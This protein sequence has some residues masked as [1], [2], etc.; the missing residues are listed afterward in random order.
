MLNFNNTN[1]FIPLFFTANLCI[2][3]F[4][5]IPLSE[6]QIIPDQ[7]LPNPTLVNQN[8]NTSVITGGTQA[9][10]N[11]FHSF[12]E[13]SI[14]SGNIASFRHN[15]DIANILSRVTGK[16]PS[17]IDGVIEVL[18]N[19][20]AA[21]S[22]NLFLINPSGIVFGQNASLN[23][24]GSFIT[25]TA[26]SFI[27][28]NGTEF[29]AVNP[30]DNQ[31]LLTINVPVGLQF[32]SNP[33][34]IIHQSQSNDVGLAV[35]P[36]KTLAFVGGNVEL[37][38]GS[39]IAP[40]GRIELGSV[41]SPGK[42]S[43]KSTESGFSLGYEGIEEF[44]DIQLSQV[45]FI[46]VSGDVGGDVT[47]NSQNLKI[48][49]GSQIASVISNQGKGS[50][51]NINTR[52]NLELA[53]GG[54]FFL[55]MNDN[56]SGKGTNLLISTNKLLI[57]NG[58]F[59]FS[60]NL[61]SGVGSDIQVKA[62]FIEF[63]G[64]NT[65]ILTNIIGTG[66]GGDIKVDTQ[67]LSLQNGSQIASITTASGKGGNIDIVVKESLTATG[68]SDSGSGIF[69]Q[70]TGT[71]TAG[72]IKI[73][74]NQLNLSNGAQINSRTFADGDA[75]EIIV[76][77]ENIDISGIALDENGEVITLFDNL[78]LNSGIFA[79]TEP[80]SSGNAAPLT[81]TTNNLNISD[82]GLVETST[83]S[84]GDGS[85]LTINAK[86]ILLSGVSK[87]EIFPASILSFSGGFLDKN[88]FSVPD[89]TGKGGSVNITT[90]NLT[91]DNQAQIAVSS[92]N[93]TDAAKGAGNIDINAEKISL[94]N[95]GKLNAQSNSGDGG[96]IKLN[97]KDLLVLRNNS[98][99]STTAGRAE[100]GG[101]G[102][103]IDINVKDGFI[104][105]VPKEDSD[106]TANAFTG[107]GGNVD[108]VTQGIFGINPAEK[109]TLQSDITASSETGIQGEISIT[110]PEID[111]SQGLIELPDGVVDRSD[112]I[113][114]ICP[115]GINAK[116]LSEFYI[117]GRGSFP[118]SPL[119][120]LEG[121]VEL[122]RLA[123]LDGESGRSG[124]SERVGRVGRREAESKDIVE[125]QGFMKTE[126]GE[127]YLVAQA[128]TAT[129]SAST[130][131]TACV[132][133]SQ[134]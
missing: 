117:T 77:A 119:N 59:I 61:T 31:P 110:D 71:G 45:S 104:V 85:T 87:N 65:G 127:I 54:N 43:L 27:F 128:P 4:A 108:I 1:L 19:N 130:S 96:N 132:Q 112:Q 33:G 92:V 66:K 20:G 67:K 99:I 49:E 52:E 75:G 14:N 103:N 24:G 57:Q 125:A 74:S 60:D 18:Q 38:N 129:P 47:I 83:L 80:N 82:G 53:S 72:K 120:P 79:S 81:I 5:K 48:A 8:N 115:R 123:S 16:L 73:D 39:L 21:S 107:N 68:V 44:G 98:S 76:N 55:L 11:L 86:N 13:F 94:L 28:E 93:P 100:Q 41:L 23:I 133:A 17:N 63:S 90:E 6:A 32:G 29:S 111:P 118:P 36:R 105:A 35:Q 37:T 70:T 26:D 101:D 46:D 62:E 42:V 64:S 89:A 102:G 114:Q 84:S 50:N 7:N 3:L 122:S 56:A 2:S 34:A 91:I 22:A 95:G 131:K 40:D 109:P 113:A 9:E 97:L 15:A 126:N 106:I 88:L 124:R 25:S 51:I 78:A 10:N 134:K 121:T 30:V 69:A 12:Q 58:A 116:K